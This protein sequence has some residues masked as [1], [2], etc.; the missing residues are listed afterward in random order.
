[1]D[2]AGEEPELIR[3]ER[4]QNET[5]RI[6]V[7]ADYEILDTEGEDAFDTFAAL[8]SRVCGTPLAGVSFVDADRQ[9]FKARVGLDATAI[10]RDDSFC[11]HTILD[12]ERVLVVEDAR[13]DP[14]FANTALVTGAPHLRFY[15]GAPL[16]APGGE[17]LGTLC[18]F[19]R[20]PRQLEQM[21][22]QMLQLLA[23][24]VVSQLELRK[25]VVELAQAKREAEEATS[26][27]TE[28]FANMGH[29]IRTPMT[30][31]MGMSELLEDTPL[32]E[33]QKEYVHVLR[34][35]G[36]RLMGLIDGILDLSRLESGRLVLRPEPLVMR[37]FLASV[38]EVAA[39]PAQTKG[40]SVAL[41]VAPDVPEAV[42]ADASRLQQILLDLL[43]NA[44]EFT[45]E[46]GI[47]LRVTRTPGSTAPGAL[48]FALIDTG[49]GIAAVDQV[50]FFRPFEQVDTAVGERHGGAGLGLSLADRLVL[51]MGGAI[52]LE[53]APGRGSTFS[54]DLVLPPAETPRVAGPEVDDGPEPAP[55]RP[56]SASA[57]PP[58]AAPDTVPVLLVDDSEDNRFLVREF[59]RETR[60]AV[61]CA[62]TAREGLEMFATERYAVVLMD[63]QLPDMDGYAATRA[64]RAWEREQRAMRTPILAL[65]ADDTEDDRQ[66]ALDAGCDEHLAKP[67]E[68]AKLLG[69]LRRFGTKAAILRM[70]PR[71]LSN[72]ASDLIAL[73]GALEAGDFAA[74]RP[75]GHKMKGTGASFGL[76][77][78]T[79]IGAALEGAAKRADHEAA[80]AAIDRLDGFLERRLPPDAGV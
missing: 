18:V 13:L 55:V 5:R 37:S 34:Q 72:R 9:W 24:A 28:F 15:A 64:M 54:F 57:A 42:S 6:A 22:L 73:R 11:A 74:M 45:K 53:S 78:V 35:A 20:E 17:A 14:R 19:D 50:R 1:M 38:L 31:I 36:V 68:R 52:A 49:I 47:V 32:T 67:F 40:L 79:D 61:E 76:R 27:K 29:E 4:P 46:G 56:P 39:K 44:V 66:A 75:I 48:R 33:E 3:V 30:A 7:L 80:R 63:V 65:T 10:A 16:V 51:L 26:A 58:Q 60:Y 77:E 21:Q 62:K 70:V 8:A 25:R 59:L 41:E 2:L 71:Y 12:P 69:T 23:R 43:G